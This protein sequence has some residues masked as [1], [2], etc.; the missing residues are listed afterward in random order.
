MVANYIIEK[1]NTDIYPVIVF[2]ENLVANSLFFWK[3]F[4]FVEL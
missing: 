1:E 4:H 2:G 3:E